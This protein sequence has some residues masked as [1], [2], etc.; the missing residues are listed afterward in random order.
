MKIFGNCRNGRTNLGRIFDNFLGNVAELDML[1]AKILF[2]IL[3][4]F[5]LRLSALDIL[6]FGLSRDGDTRFRD[7]EWQ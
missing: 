2:L 6:P 7:R 4:I 3:G 5:E 1:L